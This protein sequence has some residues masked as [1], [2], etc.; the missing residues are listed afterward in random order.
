MAI[1]EISSENGTFYQLS[2]RYPGCP[3]GNAYLSSY[4]S[5]YREVS[6]PVKDS[7]VKP[8]I[9]ALSPTGRG[10]FHRIT[11][12]DTIVEEYPPL[13]PWYANKDCNGVP[14][15]QYQ[16]VLRHRVSHTYLLDAPETNWELAVRTKIKSHAVNLGTHAVEYRETA[17]MFMDVAKFTYSTYRLMRGHGWNGRTVFRKRDSRRTKISKGGVK[18]AELYLGYQY[19][20][21]PLIG[22]LGKSIQLLQARLEGPLV[23]RVYVKKKSSASWNN[24][25]WTD[26]T[27]SRESKVQVFVT[28]KGDY[29]PFTGGNVPELVWESIPFSFVVDWLFPIGEWLSSLDALKDV[30]SMIGTLTERTTQRSYPNVSGFENAKVGILGG[31]HR[32]FYQ[33]SVLHTIPSARVPRY[34]PSTSWQ[35]IANAGALLTVL[36]GS[37]TH[38]N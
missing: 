12:S 3:E 11:R 38:F 1:S 28:H 34:T 36:R 5:A 9:P 13:S 18:A 25:S 35:T 8:A 6:I 10:P 19:G 26:G 20:V 2:H 29:T 27:A 31:S 22:D 37:T 30:E 17:K 33:R 4:E 21:K 14:N 32:E 24:V 16:R 7:R 15:V 23:R